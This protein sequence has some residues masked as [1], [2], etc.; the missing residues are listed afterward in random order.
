MYNN[1]LLLLLQLLKNPEAKLHVPLFTMCSAIRN[2]I[3][4]AIHKNFVITV[5]D[6]IIKKNNSLSHAKNLGFEDRSSFIYLY[7][8]EVHIFQAK[9]LHWHSFNS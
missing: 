6:K 8:I 5:F 4:Y 1:W 7:Y 2:T 3:F 9:K